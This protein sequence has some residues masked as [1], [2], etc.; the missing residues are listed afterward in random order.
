MNQVAVAAL[1]SVEPQRSPLREVV[2]A[3]E[4]SPIFQHEY[5]DVRFWYPWHFH[6]EVEIKQVISGSGTR[7][8]GDSIEAFAPGD[9]CLVGSGTP[10]CWTSPAVRGRWVRAR[11]VQFDPALFN[12]LP[13]A[14]LLQQARR[15]LQVT[16]SGLSDAT[17]ELDRLFAAQTETRQLGHLL[18]F[19]GIL[20]E[21]GFTRPLAADLAAPAPLDQGRELAGQ[22]L[23]FVQANSGSAL[24]EASV[25]RQFELSPSSFSRFF[26]RAFGVGFARFLA[27][28]RVAHASNLL[29]REDDD[30]AVIARRC[31]FG[32]VASLNRHFRRVKQLAPSEYRKQARRANA[33]LRAGQ[34][35]LVR[36]AGNAL[37]AGQKRA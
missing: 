4:A 14:G 23:A 20:A 33:G 36:C 1:H 30:V 25:A 12:S 3:Y 2:Q 17:A 6:P 34:R 15:G 28:L 35:E 24:S 5:C 22:V 29:L 32:T 27:E 7:V 8:V 11:F 19:L 26:S 16:R 9:L 10:H 37:A 21:A 18:T 13:V 31:G